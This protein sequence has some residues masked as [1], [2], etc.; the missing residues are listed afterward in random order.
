MRHVREIW[1]A[2][3]NNKEP[4]A[5]GELAVGSLIVTART[6]TLG[7]E[8][9]KIPGHIG[10]ITDAKYPSFIHASAKA[11]KVEER[12]LRSFSTLIGYVAMKPSH[13]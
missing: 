10:I 11:G 13:D 12:P 1:T 4:F 6:Y 7:N 5:F 2:A 3:Q 9:V 8:R